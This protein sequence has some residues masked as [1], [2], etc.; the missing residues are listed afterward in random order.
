MACG[1]YGCRAGEGLLRW[2]GGEDSHVLALI[3][4]VIFVICRHTT[5]WIIDSIFI[6]CQRMARRKSE[7]Y[8][9][10]ARGVWGGGPLLWR[11]LQS[12]NQA[13]GI[14]VVV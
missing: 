4:V 2:E 11:G 10:K 7:Q 6:A 9:R 13:S 1:G 14:R 3:L 12:V 5:C 8:F